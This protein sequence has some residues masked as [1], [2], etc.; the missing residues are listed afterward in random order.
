MK[1][2]IMCCIALTCAAILSECGNPH[3]DIVKEFLTTVQS[4]DHEKIA[5]FTKQ[6]F[7]IGLEE[8]L[9]YN[10]ETKK[11]FKEISIAKKPVETKVVNERKGD[12][13]RQTVIRAE[14]NGKFLYI[15]VLESKALGCKITAVTDSILDL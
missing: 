5:K 15:V 12:G 11:F 8:Q 13:A 14:S 10:K 4:G 1:K 9:R 7:T 2:L 3:A 6:Y